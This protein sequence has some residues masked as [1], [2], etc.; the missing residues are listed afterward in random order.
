[1]RTATIERNANSFDACVPEFFAEYKTKRGTRVRRWHGDARMLGLAFPLGCD[2]AETEPEIL[3]G[4]LADI[5][6]DKPVAE[7]DGHDVHSV[8]EDA[9]KRGIPGL[10]RRNQGTSDARGRKLHA[11]LSVLFRWLLQR[12]KVTSNPCVG[13]WHPGAPPARERT[14]TENEQRWFW[15]A[16]DQIG[17]PFGPAFQLLLITGARLNEV[18]G[19]CRDELGA[20]GAW[21]ISRTRS[22]NH[23]AHQVPLP[24]LA[25]AIIAGLPLIDSPAGF[26][27]TTTGRRPITGFSKAKTALDRAMLAQARA[28]AGDSV[29]VLPWRLHDLRRTAATGMAELGVLPHVVEAAL[30]HVSGARAG[31]AGVYNKATYG[32][33]KQA[34][35][36]RWAANV[37]G[38]VLGKPANVVHLPRKQRKR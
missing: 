5:W 20:D 6:S 35:L 7:I 13:V 10:P 26:V 23:R 12:R 11:A 34:A 18:T 24:P 16:C 15:K 25:K 3:P 31:I 1:M 28:E 2:P 21:T 8:V 29:T 17:W 19:M 37:Q 9:R 32:P 36:L 14:L 38:V 4:S 27:F 22:K 30:N 33:E